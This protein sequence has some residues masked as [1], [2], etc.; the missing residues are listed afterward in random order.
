MSL[1]CR[2]S[3]AAATSDS[4]V[5][6]V[7]PL[8]VTMPFEILAE[9]TTAFVCS[10]SVEDVIVPDRAVDITAPLKPSISLP[11]AV[12]PGAKSVMIS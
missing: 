8:N 4:E 11:A 9:L 7:P 5:R 2:N 6:L 12:A 1:A 3:I 10:C